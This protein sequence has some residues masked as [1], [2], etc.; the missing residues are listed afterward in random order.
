MNQFLTSKSAKQ[1]LLALQHSLARAEWE[2]ARTGFLLALEGGLS[3]LAAHLRREG[4][5]GEQLPADT[6]ELDAEYGYFDE[7]G[8]GDW[9]A[10]E[11]ELD[12]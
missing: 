9:Q 4:E 11:D 12:C 2:Q 7:G 3:T 1:S 10:E 6:E 5:L 8:D